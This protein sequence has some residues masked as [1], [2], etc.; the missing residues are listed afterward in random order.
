MQ[1]TILNNLGAKVGTYYPITGKVDLGTGKNLRMDKI[2]F[3]GYCDDMQW[4]LL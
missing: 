4:S 3:K 1:K 2:T